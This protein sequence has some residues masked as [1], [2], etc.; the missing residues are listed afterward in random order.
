MSPSLYS[1]LERPSRLAK[2][3]KAFETKIELWED[4]PLRCRTTVT[5]RQ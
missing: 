1:I 4:S 5:I 3:L 2:F